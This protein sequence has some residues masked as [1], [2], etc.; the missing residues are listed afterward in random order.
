M[1]ADKVYAAHRISKKSQREVLEA[2]AN[3]GITY[4]DV[5]DLPDNEVHRMLF[6]DRNNHDVPGQ[7]QP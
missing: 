5:A 7:E 4:D 1:S 3:L 2:A 6:P